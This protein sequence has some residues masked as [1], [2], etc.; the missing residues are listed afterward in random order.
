MPNEKVVYTIKRLEDSRR[1]L[2]VVLAV[3]SAIAGILALYLY[4]SERST[5]A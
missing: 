3:I 4:F 5:T 1:V 2:Q